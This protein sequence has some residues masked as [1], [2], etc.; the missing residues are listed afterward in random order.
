MLRPHQTCRERE[1]TTVKF[2]LAATASSERA[3]NQ[4]GV[5]VP[6]VLHRVRSASHLAMPWIPITPSRTFC[7]KHRTCL[8]EVIVEVR[9][10]KS[11]ELISGVMS[12]CKS[13][14]SLA[15]FAKSFYQGYHTAADPAKG[16]PVSPVLVVS[17]VRSDAISVARHVLWRF[18]FSSR[19]K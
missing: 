9:L 8:D 14:W 3:D 2:D 17:Y 18:S 19:S 4:T 16:V 6:L 15:R 12:K 1:C 5:D 7:S 13:R 11:S 10:T